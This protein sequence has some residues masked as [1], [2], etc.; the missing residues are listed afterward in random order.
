MG[1]KGGI[2][3]DAD[4]GPL[5]YVLWCCGGIC[6]QPDTFIQIGSGHTVKCQYN[7]KFLFFR[8]WKEY[9]SI[10]NYEELQIQSANI[11]GRKMSKHALAILLN[12]SDS[13]S[14]R[15]GPFIKVSVTLVFEFEE[16]DFYLQFHVETLFWWYDLIRI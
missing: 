1:L 3:I 2:S 9:E 14:R 10:H 7:L 11:F 8:I 5:R 15:S 4:S 16:A 12:Y 13:N 6:H